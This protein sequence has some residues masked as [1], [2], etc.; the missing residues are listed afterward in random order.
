MVNIFNRAGWDRES[1]V[2][3]MPVK[4]VNQRLWRSLQIPFQIAPPPVP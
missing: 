4:D 1:I 3:V 2:T